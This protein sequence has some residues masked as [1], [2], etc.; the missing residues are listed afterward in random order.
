MSSSEA[1]SEVTFGD[2]RSDVDPVGGDRSA[3]GEQPTHGMDLVVGEATAQQGHQRQV[4]VVGEAGRVARAEPVD[5]T[6][7]QARAGLA[8]APHSLRRRTGLA[9]GQ[10]AAASRVETRTMSSSLMGPL[11]TSWMRCSTSWGVMMC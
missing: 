7:D 10:P 2:R 3:L 1:S 8:V 4:V 6:L 5:D 11:T 9:S